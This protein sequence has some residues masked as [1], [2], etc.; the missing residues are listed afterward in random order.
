M[1]VFCKFAK[2]AVLIF[3]Q[4]AFLF[5]N[6]LTHAMDLVDNGLQLHGYLTQGL[7]YTS[8][9]NFLGRSDKNVSTDFRELGVNASLR[10]T[11]DV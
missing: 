7:V 3:I 10:P 9:N 11:S 1:C 8:D 4:G 2:T 5:G 6:T